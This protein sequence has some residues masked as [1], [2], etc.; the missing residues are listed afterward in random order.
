M[1]SMVR[2]NGS[3]PSMKKISTSNGEWV[4]NTLFERWPNLE[5]LLLLEFLIHKTL[6]Q[7]SNVYKLEFRGE[8]VRQNVKTFSGCAGF[9]LFRRVMD[10]LEAWTKIHAKFSSPKQKISLWPVESV[11]GFP[12]SGEI[13]LWFSKY[14]FE[15]IILDPSWAAKNVMKSLVRINSGED[16]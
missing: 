4:F 3:L 9:V 13:T 6:A 11:R 14:F 1:E 12:S 7:G 8:D 15:Y 16:M 5:E 10:A 2:S